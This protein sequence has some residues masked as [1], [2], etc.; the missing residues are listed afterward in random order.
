MGHTTPEI[1]YFATDV[2]PDALF[3][4][5]KKWACF[6]PFAN[7]TGLPA[8][9]L[10]LGHDEA[11]NLPVGMMF[12]ANHGQERLLLELA[13]QLEAASPWRTLHGLSLIHI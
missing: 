8:I 13:L 10:P 6:T 5:A 9:N 3:E 7:A 4:R 11:S 1:G 12:T 2:A